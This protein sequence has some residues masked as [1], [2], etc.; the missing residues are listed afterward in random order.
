MKGQLLK[1][2][3]EKQD[4]GQSPQTINLYLN[5]IKHF[6]KDIFKS[7]TPIDLKF[8]KTSNKLPVVL[9]RIEIEK[10]IKATKMVPVIAR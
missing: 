7:Q 6:Y 3:L 10:I 4:K 5:A 8:A 1:Y 9:S 2:L